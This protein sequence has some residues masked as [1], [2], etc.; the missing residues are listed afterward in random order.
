MN[1]RQLKSFIKSADCKS[2]SKAATSLYISTPA[3]VQQI[4]LLEDSIGFTLFER[5]HRGITLTP[6]GESFYKASVKILQIYGNACKEGVEI[7]KNSSLSLR[8]SYPFEQ[9]PAF[10][11][12][13]YEAFR[14]QYA[15]ISV[16][17]ISLPFNEHLSAISNGAADLSVIAEP[18]KAY[19]EELAFFPL[20][21]ETYSFCMRPDHPLAKNSFI[22]MDDLENIKIIC[23]RYEYLKAPF[24]KQ[25]AFSRAILQPIDKEYDMSTR[26]K[27]LISDEIIVIHSLWSHSCDLFL[28][29]IPSNIPAGRVGVIYR[30]PPPQ[31]VQC[32]LPFLK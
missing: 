31:L 9:F 4:N 20:G 28:K 30:T 14:R 19:L 1:E 24:A 3:L 18:S 32:F 21:E 10:L 17:F 5:T 16:D 7:E 15:S 11:L 2:F 13:A 27:S 8:I 25:L 22:T 12:S 29:V 23:G 6:A 26:I